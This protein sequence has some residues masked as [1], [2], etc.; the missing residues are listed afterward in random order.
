MLVLGNTECI[1]LNGLDDISEENLGRQ[2][3]SVVDN[4]LTVWSVPAIHCQ[5]WAQQQK[6]LQV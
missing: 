3:V 4:W 1:V 6:M 2:C 5:T